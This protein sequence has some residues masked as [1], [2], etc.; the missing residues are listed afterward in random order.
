VKVAEIMSRPVVTVTPGT[1]IKV[2]AQ[3]LV[4]H[5][6]SA[7]PVLDA[8]GGLV[9]IVSEADLVPMQTRPDPRT[10]ATPPSPTAGRTP[11]IVADV[12]TR[13]VVSV[14]AGSEV[15]QAA[16]TMLEAGIKRVPV[17]TGRRVVGIVSRRDLVRVIARKDDA[18]RSELAQRL[19]EAGLAAAAETVTVRSGVAE[20]ALVDRG[21]QRRLSESLALSVPGVLEVRFTS[22]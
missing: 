12:M 15:S 21:P 4:E 7:L 16:R 1:S 22:P 11:R 3:M 10:Q 2:A 6:I 8:G 13:Q 19:A 18:V 20:I 17:L 9:G 5:G 14:T